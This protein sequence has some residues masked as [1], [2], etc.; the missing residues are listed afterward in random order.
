LRA[1]AVGFLAG[2]VTVQRGGIGAAVVGHA[3]TR[4]AFFVA[5]GRVGPMRAS[6]AKEEIAEQLSAPGEGLAVVN[7]QAT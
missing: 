4:L 6:V 2:W 7:D 1:L 5:S 3:M